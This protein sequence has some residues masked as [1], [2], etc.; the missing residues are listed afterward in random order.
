MSTSVLFDG[1]GPLVRTLVVGVAAYVALVLLL[2]LFGKRTLSK[3]NAFDFI[4][5]IALGSTLASVLTS[6]DVSLAQGVTAL[7]VLI[8][9]QYAVTWG[10]TRWPRF[11]SLVTSEPRL[12]AYQ[13]ALL[14]SALRGE[15]V[16]DDE[17]HAALRDHGVADL[18]QAA[19]VVLETDGTLTVIRRSDEVPGA[20]LRA[21]RGYPPAGDQGSYPA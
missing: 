11:R 9:L 1:W 12:L 16:A 10:G 13:G 15:R 17:V 4:V 8:A 5:T 14:D 3:F 6:K 18:A 21:V 19:A 20:P 7:G 2:R